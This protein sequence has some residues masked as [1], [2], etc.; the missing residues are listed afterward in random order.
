MSKHIYACI[1]DNLCWII[2]TS[3]NLR[4]YL[5]I[6]TGNRIDLRQKTFTFCKKKMWI[7]KGGGPE[8]LHKSC[9]HFTWNFLHAMNII[10]LWSLPIFLNSE[11][12]RDLVGLIKNLHLTYYKCLYAKAFIV[13]ERER[14]KE[15]E[16]PC[17]YANICQGYRLLFPVG[18][19]GEEF[20]LIN[21]RF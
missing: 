4:Q 8:K 16:R 17:L 12:K 1:H 21:F 5:T 10:F 19:I 6:G 2:E 3:I 9:Q 20:L 14:E 15:R 11:S 18:I 13:R 7:G